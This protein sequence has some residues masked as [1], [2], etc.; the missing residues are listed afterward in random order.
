[1]VDLEDALRSPR[2]IPYL[3]RKSCPLMLPL[4]PRRISAAD[5]AAALSHRAIE[6]PDL[7]RLLLQG[8]HRSPQVTMDAADAER[9]DL[10]IS[11]RELS[12]DS[13]LSRRRWQFALREE[14]ILEVPP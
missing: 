9:F 6:R 11:R 14:A 13:L 7:E 2:F 3:G 10:P 12:R 5:P 4:A 1:L 8:S